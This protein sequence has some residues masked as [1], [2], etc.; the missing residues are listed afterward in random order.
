MVGYI[1]RNAMQKPAWHNNI[2]CQ[3][4]IIQKL[5]YHLFGT[6]NKYG[7]TSY[8]AKKVVNV[9]ADDSIANVTGA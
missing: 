5:H 4:R 2:S 3:N 7:R 1:K 8:H 6:H 9:K